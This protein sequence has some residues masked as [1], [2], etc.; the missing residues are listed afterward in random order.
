MNRSEILK[1]ANELTS[2]DREQTHGTVADNFE[3][4]AQLWSAYLQSSLS[5]KD[6][7][8]MMALL[9][10]ARTKTGTVNL[11]DFIDGAAYVAIGGE[12]DEP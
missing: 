5:K 10:I 8:L 7:A 1:I 2:Q 4:I 9:K 6:V 12:L 3:N 11:D